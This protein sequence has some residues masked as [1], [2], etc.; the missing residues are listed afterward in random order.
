M[1]S[2]S[3]VEIK[4]ARAD[5]PALAPGRAVGEEG[6][7]LGEDEACVALGSN[8]GVRSAH[9]E[10]A[11][12]KMKQFATILKISFLYE[13]E[14]KYFLDQPRFLNCVCKIK[15]SLSS[16]QLLNEL[17]RIET[18]I[19]RERPLVRNGPRVIDLDI[20]LHGRAPLSTSTLTI[21]HP[22]LHER[23]FVLG[24]LMDVQPDL[25]HPLL[26]KSVRQ[27]WADLGE[28]EGIVAVIPVV[29]NGKEV[30][31]SD[32]RK[33]LLMAVC[34]MTPDSFSDGG[35]LFPLNPA[36]LESLREN[37]LRSSV[38]IID[39]GGESS[40]PG[41][42][43]VPGEEELARITPLLAW[44]RAQRALDGVLVSVDTWKSEVAKSA[45]SQGANI[46][47]DYTAGK[48][49]NI[50]KVAAETGAPMILMHSRGTPKTMN[51]LADYPKGQEMETI[52]AE[53]NVNIQKALDQGIFPWKIITD[54]GIGFAKR[55][56][57][58][59]VILRNL[60]RWKC[61][62]HG[63]P[64]LIGTSRKRFISEVCGGQ[65]PK[66]RVWGTAATITAAVQAGCAIVRVHDFQPL[67]Q[68]LKMSDTLYKNSQ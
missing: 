25:V 26:K 11:L 63:Y 17:K 18:E 45:I 58:N 50:F 19:G 67:S 64:Y 40:R 16:A 66:D 65:D 1:A 39:I 28:C 32:R 30:I 44:A 53:L 27:L 4:R 42:E 59:L 6:A 60:G 49:P 21:P 35:E 48:D 54:P 52:A 29:V 62:T 22:Q 36:K 20:L 43:E 14:P 41:A 2:H 34:N 46:I 31:L 56:E 33:T 51:Q 13:T 3:G 61:L 15:T 55:G 37:L 24:P 23:D 7:F 5:Y 38:D 12:S 9:I 8:L 10:T 57:H 68:V 47:N